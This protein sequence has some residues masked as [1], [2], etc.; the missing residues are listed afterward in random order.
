MVPYA[1][2]QKV[3]FIEGHGPVL[4]DFNN[5]IFSQNNKNS[6][7]KKL[8]PVYEAINKSREKLDKDKSLIGFV[9]APWTLLI[10]M[11]DLKLNKRD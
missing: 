5:K 6:F 3:N 10:Y 8:Q 1:L 11:L 9:G 4:E 7:T 2:G